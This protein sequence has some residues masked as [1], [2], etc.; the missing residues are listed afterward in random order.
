[1]YL[2]VLIRLWSQNNC[3]K[4]FTVLEKVLYCGLGGSLFFMTSS[5]GMSSGLNF[6]I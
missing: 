4:D 1:M 6:F 3:C 2:T 5:Q